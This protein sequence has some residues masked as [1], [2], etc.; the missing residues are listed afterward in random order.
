MLFPF[1]HIF[2][3]MM[4]LTVK[5][6]MLMGTS[7]ICFHL[8]GCILFNVDE[9]RSCYLPSAN[10][11]SFKLFSQVIQQ[12]EMHGKIKAWGSFTLNAKRVST[13]VQ[14]NPNQPLLLEMMY[15]SLLL[16]F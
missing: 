8:M 10:F 7:M 15:V 12:I 14:K 6:V 5:K 11:F 4:L 3:F 13:R 1:I 2:S 16:L 9:L